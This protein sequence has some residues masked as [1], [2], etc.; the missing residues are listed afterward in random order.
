MNAKNSKPISLIDGLHSTPSRRYLS[1]K[2]ISDKIIWNII[3][4]AIRGPSGGNKQGWAWIVIRD[5][6]TKTKI[7]HWYLEN[8]NK[9]YGVRREEILSGAEN[10]ALGPKNFLSADHLANHIQ[11]APVWIIPVLRDV[12]GSQNPRAGSSI[13]GSVQNLMLAARAYG[14]G[15]TLTALHS[16]NETEV[17]NLLNLPNDALAMAIIP[18]GYPF[19][20]RWSQPKRKPV[21]EVTYWESWNVKRDRPTH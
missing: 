21:E 13:Y 10:D 8:W 12:A 7:A 6:S 14:I 5:K 18:L 11:D 1:D 17:K 4:A 16:P 2:P 15:S 20:G 9:V 3:D 19:K